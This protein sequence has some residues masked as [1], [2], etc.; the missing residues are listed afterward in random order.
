MAVALDTSVESHTGT[1]GNTASN[2]FSWSHTAAAGTKGVLVFCFDANA[3]A[4]DATAVTFGTASLSAVSGGLASDTAGEPGSCQAWFLGSGVPT[5]AQTVTV[6]RTSNA[7]TMYA[8]SVTLIGSANLSVV[9]T[10]LF[11]E[12]GALAEASISDG[13]P[14]T[15]S[16]RLAAGYTGNAN[17]PTAS[18]SSTLAQSIDL[19]S[20]G[21]AV[22]Y[23]TT[24]GQG[25]RNVGLVVAS[26]D[27]AAVYLAVREGTG[28]AKTGVGTC[29]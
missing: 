1:T 17:P 22:A 5:G 24:P 9:G 18:S 26:D 8:V 15:N 14:G 13:S 2:S 27:R 28:Y 6:T 19:G 11:Q 29:I 21:C 23:E 20:F 12:D 10:T 25:A 4:H 7:N 3:N 16:L